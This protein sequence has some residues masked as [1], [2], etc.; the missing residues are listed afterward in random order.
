[1]ESKVDCSYSNGPLVDWWSVLSA[2]KTDVQTQTS[3]PGL[4]HHCACVRIHV[5]PCTCVHACPQSGIT[6]TCISFRTRPCVKEGHTQSAAAGKS[7]ACYRCHYGS[8]V[9]RLHW[10]KGTTDSRF[11]GE[12]LR[13]RTKRTLL[14]PSWRSA[15]GN[16][17]WDQLTVCLNVQL[18]CL[19]N[20]EFT[21]HFNADW[22]CQ[23][24]ILIRFLLI[25][26]YIV[27][28]L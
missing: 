12:G 16:I 9:T 2:V 20:M 4:S 14:Q 8:L 17:S 7:F 1:M 24:K 13:W 19:Y 28:I 27:K 15:P 18:C 25:N 6:H 10:A 3:L 5:C 11:H 21:I 23:T 22:W 26:Q